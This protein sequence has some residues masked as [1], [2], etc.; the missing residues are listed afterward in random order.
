[1]T[2]WGYIKK[3]NR[4]NYY[5]GNGR[6][7]QLAEDMMLA[8]RKFLLLCARGVEAEDVWKK[9]KSEYERLIGIDY[10]HSKIYFGYR[11]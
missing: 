10:Y 5:K 1:M 4:W 9:V 11:S 6:N 8:P 3:Q 7:P 2:V